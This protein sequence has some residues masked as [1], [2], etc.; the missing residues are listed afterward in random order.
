MLQMKSVS[1][2]RGDGDTRRW[3]MIRQCCVCQRVYED[4]LWVAPGPEVHECEEITHSYCD[5]CSEDFLRS[6]AEYFAT[7]KADFSV[8]ANI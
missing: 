5:D 2:A 6:V 4:G 8:A 7:P 1:G 3:A